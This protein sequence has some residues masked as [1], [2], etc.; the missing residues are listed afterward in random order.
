[1]TSVATDQTG[2]EERLDRLERELRAERRG[3]RW[4]RVT[5]ALTVVGVVVACVTEI[6]PKVLRVNEFVVEDANGKTRIELVVSTEGPM[7]AMYDENR[8]T[9]LGLGVFPS[10]SGLQLRDANG[11][12][13]IGLG[14]LPAGPELFLYDETGKKLW[15]QP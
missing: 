12:T 10:G 3:N 15:S 6:R 14:V 13:R 5:L 1:M 8:T 11:K 2:L 7:L 4:L 9:R